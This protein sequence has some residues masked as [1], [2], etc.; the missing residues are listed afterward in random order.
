MV[1]GQSNRSDIALSP[2]GDRSF[3]VVAARV[4][5]ALTPD[6]ISSTSLP[7]FERLLKTELFP[8][9][10]P[11]C[12]LLRDLNFCYDICNVVLQLLAYL[13]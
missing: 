8:G 5:N 11:N 12:I 6:V 7:A 9:S 10:S 3:P 13:Y 2:V 1:V 4:C